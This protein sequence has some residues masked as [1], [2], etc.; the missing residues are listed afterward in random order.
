MDSALVSMAEKTG[1]GGLKKMSVKDT[2]RLHHRRHLKF[3][4][5]MEEEAKY[6]DQEEININ[7]KVIKTVQTVALKVKKSDTIHE[8]KTKFQSV[9]GVSAKLQ[10]LFLSGNHLKD[11]KML[12]D[13]NIR[14]G[15]TINLHVRMG[16][17]MKIY[18]EMPMG[19]TISLDVKEC[20]TIQRIK[21]MIHD[22]H[23]IP[24]ER[25]TLILD[26][27]A[28]QDTHTLSACNI[29][30]ESTIHMVVQESDEMEILVNFPDGEAATFAVRTWYTIWDV[31][32]LIKSLTHVTQQKQNL[33][34]D[35]NQLHD[36]LTL[37]DISGRPVLELSYSTQIYLMQIVIKSQLNQIVHLNVHS[38]E[39]VYN[40]KKRIEEEIGIP[41]DQQRLIFGGRQ[42]D[43]SRT[44]GDYNVQDGSTIHV[45][46]RLRGS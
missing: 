11:N 36:T 42:M 32:T 17:E 23:C 12:A 30:T 13:Y 14:D 26:G 20:D 18:V 35:G 16:Q 34:Y 29:T 46:L 25:Q 38:G 7:L 27:T 3:Q 39:Y 37:A 9:E 5:S 24:A 19:K 15:S 45:I 33:I 8:L 44:V 28:L 31:K 2:L 41:P 22:K 4:L 10:E 1:M 40:L 21:A 6:A 43:D